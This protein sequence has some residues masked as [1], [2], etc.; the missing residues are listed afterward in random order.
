M[1]TTSTRDED[2]DRTRTRLPESPAPL[3]AARTT[4]RE[5]FTEPRFRLL[6]TTRALAIVGDSL[7]ISTL[8]VLVFALSGSP[9][10]SAVAFS[11]GF[12]PQLA[13]SM[14]LGSLSDRIRPRVL[15]WGGYALDAAVTATPGLLHLPVAPILLLL[16]AL[17]LLNP[18]FNGASSRLTAELLSGD[19]YVLGR[20]LSNMS[21]SAAQLLGLAVGGT[22]VAVLG[23]R[24]ALLVAAGILAASAVAVRL[25]L[26]NLSAPRNGASRAADGVVKASWAG[27]VALLRSARLR[28]LFMAQWLPIGFCV[29][30]ESLIVAYTAQRHFPAGIYAVLLAS[31]PVG[32]LLGDLLVGRLIRPATRERLVVW[33]VALLGLPL[34]LFALAPSAVLSAVLFF[35]AA[36]GFS[37]NLGLQRIFLEALPADSQGQAFGLLNSGT[38]T[39]QGLGPAA[40]GTLATL[41]SAERAIA[42]AGVA[43]AATAVWIASWWG[44]D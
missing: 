26:P 18:V 33:L 1:T 25:R 3:P 12:L 24:T 2:A 36:T 23:P 6:F 21:S 28:R 14:L 7:R 40:A 17:A 15:I 29:G 11:I 42:V 16:A 41:L 10:L 34:I 35:L 8:S 27:N 44:H 43:T 20:S 38:M 19:A 32:M 39:A 31:L 4:Y 13:G 30:A 9:L 22:I 5:V 37:Y